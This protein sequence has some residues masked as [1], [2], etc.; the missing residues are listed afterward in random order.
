M[1]IGFT[2]THVQKVDGKGRMSIPAPY[3][4]VL[5]AGDPD[6]TSGGPVTGYMVY[7]RHLKNSLHVFSVK[8]FA[9]RAREIE[10]MPDSDPNKNLVRQMV[11]SS[12]EPI[13]IDKDGRTVLGLRHRQKLGVDE[14]EL[15]FRGMMGHF[16]IWRKDIYEET[17]DDK[18]D[19]F[20]AD[21]GED[22]DPFS[23]VGP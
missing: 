9:R 11:V 14:G 17:V 22:F 15:S 6:W 4:R 23:L 16:E 5:E 1:L 20:L 8:E 12:S 2:G 21:K 13:Q 10:A 7:G 3:R 18:L 19:A